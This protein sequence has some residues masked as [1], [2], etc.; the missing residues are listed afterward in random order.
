[1]EHS[2]DVGA[3]AGASSVMSLRTGKEI[4]IVTARKVYMGGHNWKHRLSVLAVVAVLAGGLGAASTSNAFAAGNEIGSSANITRGNPTRPP[5]DTGVGRSLG[6][7]VDGT[8]IK[9]ITEVSG[10]KIDQDVI[11]LSRTPP[12]ANMLSRSYPVD[13]SLAR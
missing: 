9:R 4:V 5:P 7:E 6:L 2:T 8:V 13:R 3:C 1:M 12:T 10:L 11:E